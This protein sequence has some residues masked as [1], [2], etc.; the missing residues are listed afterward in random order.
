MLLP[1]AAWASKT[2]YVSSGAGA[3]ARQAGDDANPGTKALPFKTLPKAV[4][5]LQSGD[6]LVVRGSEYHTVNGLTKAQGP[7]LIPSGTSW[8]ER[9][10][11]QGI[12]GREAR[13]A[14]LHAGGCEGGRDH[15]PR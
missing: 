4:A 5:A 10:D 13:H 1:P 12:P 2:Y 15:L 6:T 9:D 7:S 8:G 3:G 14:P 11:P